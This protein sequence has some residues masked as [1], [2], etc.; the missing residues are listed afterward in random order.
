MNTS[1]TFMLAA[2]TALSFGMGTA[3]AQES[4]GGYIAGPMEQRELLAQSEAYGAQ[5][6]SALAAQAHQPQYGSSDRTN[7]SSW[8]VLEGGDG[9]GG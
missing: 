8:P 4:A 6:K 5:V 7:E 3:M 1:K 9:S 2:A